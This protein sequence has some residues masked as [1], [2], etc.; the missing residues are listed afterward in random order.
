MKHKPWDTE[1]QQAEKVI[2]SAVKSLAKRAPE[3]RH[4]AR[5]GALYVDLQASGSD[6]SRPS[7]VS[8]D[9]AK[10]LLSDAANDYAGQ[11]D[12]LKPDLL[13]GL[14]DPKLADTLESWHERP[15]LPEP[16][17]PEW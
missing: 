7:E 2:Q 3:N 6:W 11:R 12:R 8:R 14:G 5:I 17:W 15:T 1:Y 10:K 9:D 13:R 16:V 4:A